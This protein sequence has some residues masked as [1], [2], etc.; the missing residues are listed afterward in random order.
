[1]PNFWHPLCGEILHE[2]ETDPCDRRTQT[3]R[4]ARYQCYCLSIC[5]HHVLIG[6]V[7]NT[8][9]LMETSKIFPPSFLFLSLSLF[10][11]QFH[12]DSFIPCS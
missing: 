3:W 5:A 9:L 8:Q 7:T 11:Q 2:Q 6:T 12:C 4:K 1:M 10:H